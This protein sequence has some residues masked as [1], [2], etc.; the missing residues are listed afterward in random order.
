MTG[1]SGGGQ[2]KASLVRPRSPGSNLLRSALGRWPSPLLSSVPGSLEPSPGL[3]VGQTDKVHGAPGCGDGVGQLAVGGFG[4]GEWQQ[5]DSLAG[6]AVAGEGVPLAVG[7]K[8]T[9]LWVDFKAFSWAGSSSSRWWSSGFCCWG[10]AE[11]QPSRG[12]QC[13]GHCGAGQRRGEW[14]VGTPGLD[15]VEAQR[16]PVM[17]WILAGHGQGMGTWNWLARCSSR[18]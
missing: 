14:A 15:Q 18:A 8:A 16:E 12:P 7:V 13:S 2:A 5:G 6:P 3:P 10:G 9:G 4:A 17:P 11:A 1:L